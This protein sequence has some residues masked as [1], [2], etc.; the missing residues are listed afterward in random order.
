MENV[1]TSDIQKKGLNIV[2]Q[3]FDLEEKLKKLDN[4]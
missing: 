3:L 1:S 4:N 2:G